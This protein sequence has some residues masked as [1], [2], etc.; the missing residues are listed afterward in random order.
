MNMLLVLFIQ[1]LAGCLGH[2][3]DGVVLEAPITNVADAGITHPFAIPFRYLPFF[4]SIFLDPLPEKF[5]S[6]SRVGSLSCP[7]LIVHGVLDM[8][9]PIDQGERMYKAALSGGRSDPSQV[10]F[11]VFPEAGHKQIKNSPKFS[12][13]LRQF[14][15]L[16]SGDRLENT[17]T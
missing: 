2:E 17:Y 4:R 7:L 6:L 13:V 5:D 10:Y 9:I 11:E 15:P 1:G 12:S 8:V 14:I 3:P 16:S